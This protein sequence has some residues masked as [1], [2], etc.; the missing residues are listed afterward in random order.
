MLKAL[1]AGLAYFAGIFCVGFALGTVRVLLLEGALKETVLVLLELPFILTV[2]WFY[3]GALIRWFGLGRNANKAW[4]MGGTALALLLGAEGGVSLLAF[5]RSFA[6]HLNHY[7]DAPGQ[8]GL[9]GQICFALIPW[10]QQR[11]GR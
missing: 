10:L 7:A 3:A 11:L 6:E 8:L 4:V 1:A 9:A 2:S 5:G